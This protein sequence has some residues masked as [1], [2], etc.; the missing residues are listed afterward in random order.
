MKLVMFTNHLTLKKYALLIASALPAAYFAQLF[1]EYFLAIFLLCWLCL[2]ALSL[3]LLRQIH[4]A[5]GGD[6]L[7]DIIAANTNLQL[8]SICV[9]RSND[10]IIITDA[11]P[12]D[13][14]ARKILYVNH[15]FEKVTGYSKAE[16]IGRTPKMLHGKNTDRD[17][18]VRI[19]DKLRL[20][21][22]VR[23]TVLNYTK[24][25]E[26]FWSEI[27]ITPVLD[28]AG[29]LT[30]WMSVQRD[31]TQTKAV[32]DELS[33]LRTCLSQVSDVV[34]ITD[35][36][37]V[38]GGDR[39]IIY[40][41]DAFAKMT[42]YSREE[43]LGKNPRILQG[44]QTNRETTKRLRTDLH[45][46]K[47]AHER[48]LNYKKD[49]T[50]FWVELIINP[51]AD[52]KGWFTHWVAIQRDVTEQVEREEQQRAVQQLAF[53]LEAEKAVR[54]EDEKLI[55]ESSSR[56]KTAFLSIMSHEIR[57][58]LNAILG[59][60]Q[61]LALNELPVSARD[62]VEKIG[63]ASEHL[64]GVMNDILDYSKIESGE[65]Q[66]RHQAL[67]VPSLLKESMDLVLPLAAKKGLL[68][69]LLIE[70]ELPTDLRGDAQRLKQVL[71]NFLSN[72]I[73]FTEA[74]TVTLH[75]VLR[76]VDDNQAVVQFSVTDTGIGMTDQQCSELFKVFQQGDN[77]FSRKYGGTGL[78]L[79]ISK[80]FSELMGGAVGVKSVVGQGSTF[81]C[82]VKFERKPN[83]DSTLVLNAQ[84]VNP[85]NE[86][87]AHLVAAD[88]LE[89]LTQ[90]SLTVLVAEDDAFNQI[91]AEEMLNL[92][93]ISVDLADNG[94]IALRKVQEKQYDMV[95][96]DLQMPVMDG[97]KATLA[98]RK[99]P[100][101][102]NLPIIA[103]TANSTEHDK[104]LCFEAGM[105]AFIAKPV[106]LET[107]CQTL[108]NFVKV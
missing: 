55:A 48:V 92:V 32:S 85:Q 95:L 99:L 38:D 63:S 33:L 4:L 19:A 79:V 83:S 103:M 10:V 34:L 21:Q 88:V 105:N 1:P 60:S 24:S 101:Q 67:H 44:D 39:K 56:E 82:T 35:A 58:P 72:A 52:K 81:W 89:R 51:I 53:N 59:F 5:K 45:K 23:E 6:P 3:M 46:W 41:N 50:P 90:A 43:V 57:T 69:E 29:K 78:G 68:L 106:L 40:V 36:E 98:I 25:G 14:A 73:K 31:V 102:A 62:K 7:C 2:G 74:G 64:L 15:A 8:L 17:T 13:G 47:T 97:I 104:Q 12:F 96:M 26:Q 84:D 9:E 27:D 94:E 86:A 30:H 66:V 18:R 22:P 108:A 80:R 87:I 93:G 20:C 42:G 100:S 65:M 37:P 54:L 16:A 28:A 49:G 75:A 91:V 70:P 107:L 11:E 61:L 71:F 77:S 76:S